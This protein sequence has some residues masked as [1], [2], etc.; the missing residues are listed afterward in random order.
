[1][2]ENTTGEV[3]KKLKVVDT[4]L[5]DLDGTLVDSIDL[6][7]QSFRFS[8]RQVLGK[9]FPDEE[10]LKDIGIPLK[11]QMEALSQ[12]KVE[13]LIGVYQKFYNQNHD[14]LIKNYPQVSSVLGELELKGYKLGVVT[15]KRRGSSERNLKACGLEGYFKVMV[16]FED[17]TE[18]KPKPAPVL[19]ALRRLNSSP[20]G[21]LLVGDSPYDIEAGRKAGVLTAAALWGPYDLERL[22][23]SRPHILLKD[24]K[25]LLRIL[26]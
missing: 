16:A 4:I 20:S 6:I 14:R 13:E 5:F 25:E 11:F 17:V 2:E 12:T 26:N 22:L 19:E 10:L 1:M 9:T 3:K 23:E 7:R 15:S 21:A 8:T 24:I 18:Y